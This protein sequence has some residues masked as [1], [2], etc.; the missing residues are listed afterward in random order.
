MCAECGVALSG[1]SPRGRSPP[2]TRGGARVRAWVAPFV[3][4][5][6]VPPKQQS[7]SVCRAVEWGARRASASYEFHLSLFYRPLLHGR[8]GPD[9]FYARAV[10]VRPRLFRVSQTA[11]G[12]SSKLQ[13]TPQ[14]RCAPPLV[15][16]SRH[17]C[18][19][20]CV[21]SF[22]SAAVGGLSLPYLALSRSFSSLRGAA[23]RG[24]RGPGGLTLRWSDRLQNA[25]RVRAGAKVA[26]TV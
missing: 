10:Y 12:P 25:S 6:S 18:L 15:Q 1:A 8:A 20:S 22:I 26:R 2:R 14:H 7:R 9:T 23:A 17:C 4:P 3:S 5:F 16:R 19:H 24:T 11:L 13:L 21:T